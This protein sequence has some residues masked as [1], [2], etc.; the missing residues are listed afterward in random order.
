MPV[1]TPLTQQHLDG[2]R[3]AVLRHKGPYAD[4]PNAYQWLYG[5][6]LP[7]SGREIRDSL[8]F[9]KYLNNPREVAPTELLSEIYLPLK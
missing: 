6:W 1:E 5:T 8:M 3:Y 7:Q 2:G 4:M 9:E